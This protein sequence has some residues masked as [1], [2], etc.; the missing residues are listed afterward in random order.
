MNRRDRNRH[1]DGKGTEMG[2]GLNRE[3]GWGS[4]TGSRLGVF[5]SWDDLSPDVR[6]FPALHSPQRLCGETTMAAEGPPERWDLR[7]IVVPSPA[8]PEGL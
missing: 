8:G 1:G 5:L 3:W 4:G 7:A 6:E 2:M